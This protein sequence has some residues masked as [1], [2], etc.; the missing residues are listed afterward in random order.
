MT[1]YYIENKKKNVFPGKFDL[2]SP[3]GCMQRSQ[4]STVQRALCC[5]WP[6]PFPA[7]AG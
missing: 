1:T 7:E 6:V 2:L 5:A 3:W 4:W